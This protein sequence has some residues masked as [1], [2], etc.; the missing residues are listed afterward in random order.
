MDALE[1]TDYDGQDKEQEVS[2]PDVRSDDEVEEKAAMQNNDPKEPE[3]AKSSGDDKVEEKAMTENADME[4]REYVTSWGDRMVVSNSSSS[5]SDSS[6]GGNHSVV[7]FVHIES[8][9]EKNDRKECIDKCSSNRV[10]TNANKENIDPI[11]I[12]DDSDGGDGEEVNEDAHSVGS[13]AKGRKTKVT[14]KR[15]TFS[16]ESDD[17]SE[18]EDVE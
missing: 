8:D 13:A 1:K 16:N 17:G 15:R 14:K 12:D 3:D 9:D 18:H 6:G 10:N 5:Q 11:V 7:T 4:Q 2:Q